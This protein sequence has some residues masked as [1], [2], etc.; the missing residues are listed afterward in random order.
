MDRVLTA[1]YFD[2]DGCPMALDPIG[3]PDEKSA[4]VL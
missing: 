1:G 3:N 2:M 4:G